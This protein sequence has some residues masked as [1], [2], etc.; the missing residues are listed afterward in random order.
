MI[1]SQRKERYWMK[2]SVRGRNE[3]LSKPE[4]RFVLR[5]FAALLIESSRIVKNLDVHVKCL[6]LDPL[7]FGYCSPRDF[8]RYQ[9][10]EFT[11]IVNSQHDRKKQIRTLAHE[12][13]HLKQYALGELWQYGCGD[14][15]WMGKRLPLDEGAYRKLPW[16]IEA[17][18]S[19]ESLV[20]Y[21]QKTLR[22]AG[23]RF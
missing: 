15:K 21:Y 18:N 14:Y 1:Q 6:K 23:M 20:K 13:V 3:N 22:E 2:I 17:W 9:S 16:E 5:T 8:D 12:M 11:V 7:D 10:R 4:I 19:E